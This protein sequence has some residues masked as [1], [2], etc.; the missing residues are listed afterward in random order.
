MKCIRAYYF[1]PSSNLN[2]FYTRYN[3]RHLNIKKRGGWNSSEKWRTLRNKIFRSWGR[4]SNEFDTCWHIHYWS[5]PIYIFLCGFFQWL[6][7]LHS[8]HTSQLNI[9]RKTNSRANRSPRGKFC[10]GLNSEKKQSRWLHRIDLQ[11]L[12]LNVFFL[13]VA[14]VSN[15]FQKW[16]EGKKVEIPVASMLQRACCCSVSIILWCVL[17]NF[18]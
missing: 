6:L 17:M 12:S 11:H 4:Q 7:H 16:L 15:F 10:L 13:I 18:I 2:C 1:F 3:L 9:I 14:C 5:D 8:W